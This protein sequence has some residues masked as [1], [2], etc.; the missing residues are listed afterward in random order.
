MFLPFELYFFL[1][2]AS[3]LATV[4]PAQLPTASVFPVIAL[5]KVVLPQLGFPAS[6]I[7]ILIP[8]QKFIFDIDTHYHSICKIKGA[9]SM[10]IQAK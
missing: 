5:Y 6:A 10:D 4:T 2:S 8:P 7:F 3:F 1:S 9:I